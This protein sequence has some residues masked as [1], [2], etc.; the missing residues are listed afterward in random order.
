MSETQALLQKIT[1]LRQRLEQVR[2][3]ADD[4][5]TAAA[6]LARPEA[7]A[8]SAL[9]VLEEKVKAGSW[10]DALL[11][12][13]LRRLPG[14]TPTMP[15]PHQLTHRARSL[16]ERGGEL[17]RRLRE[18]GEDR[19]LAEP[20]GEPLAAWY[21]ATVAMADTALR[22]V[23]AFPDAPSA[24]LRLAEGVAV[25]I[26]AVADRIHRLTALLDWRRREAGWV[27]TLADLLTGLAAGESVS[28]EPLTALADAILDDAQG[29]APFRHLCAGPETPSR[30]AAC[31]GLNVARV[32]ARVVRQDPDLSRRPLEVV[33]AALVHDAGML[34][35]PAEVLVQPGPLDDAARRAIEAHPRAGAEWIARVLPAGTWLAEAVADHHER[36]DGTGYPAGLR[37]RQIA[38]LARLLAVCDVYTA[39]GSP[40]PHRPAA[41]SRAAL[42]DTLLL[43]ERGSLDRFA[44]E[45]L[46]S[47]GFYPVGSVVELADGAI[48]VVVATPAGRGDLQAP[49]RP[50]LMLFTDSQGQALAVAQPLDLARCD[51]RSI[52]RSLPPAER[53][54]LVGSRY[55]EHV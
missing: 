20:E 12:D 6:S 28:P 50:V 1:A 26:E 33:L 11:D 30:F 45:R 37:E 31:H 15:L 25:T 54:A 2:G 21:R 46:L 44:A 24:Q 48:G 36:L 18:L 27:D 42:A 34:R 55:P 53:R 3:L 29:G 40:R 52:V 32:A 17:L 9:Q 35:V 14:T 39:L 41:E 43:A 4:A 7:A 19:L 49:A 38:P 51:G 13:S 22:M 5:G 47:L 23:S 10:Y 8:P 16:L